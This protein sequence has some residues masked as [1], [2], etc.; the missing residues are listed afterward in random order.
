MLHKAAELSLGSIASR[1]AAGQYGV[2]TIFRVAMVQWAAWKMEAFQ[3]AQQ[4]SSLL[5]LPNPI[6]GD[7]RKV[8]EKESMGPG[9]VENRPKAH[10]D[11]VGEIQTYKQMTTGRCSNNF[12]TRL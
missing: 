11:L 7:L 3:K 1:F 8:R 10:G 6:S 12:R 5:C 9:R 2:S 4:L